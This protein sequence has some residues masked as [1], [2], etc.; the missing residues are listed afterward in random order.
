MHIYFWNCNGFPWN[1]GIGIKELT[2]EPDIIFLAKTWD[3]ETQRI[4][5]T[6]TYNVHSL[7]WPRNAKQRRGNGGIAC[8]IKCGLEA[9]I[10]VIKEDTHK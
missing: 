6:S 9:H 10:A 5:N 1:V 2:N 7:L 4:M 3:H 8:M